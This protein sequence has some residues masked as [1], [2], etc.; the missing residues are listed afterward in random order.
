MTEKVTSFED[1]IYTAEYLKFESFL[2]EL[3]NQLVPVVGPVRADGDMPKPEFQRLYRHPAALVY[4]M[5][6]LYT[7]M[8]PLLRDKG[9]ME[10][11]E[12]LNKQMISLIEADEGAILVEGMQI[13]TRRLL[14]RLPTFIG[15]NP[16]VIRVA[17]LAA[18]LQLQLT[19]RVAYV[20]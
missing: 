19:R 2:Y 15:R 6:T 18:S 14:E 4:C 13:V 5:V 17:N 16:L 20:K 9:R 1:Y 12:I 3:H 10:E 7:Q 8:I 11:A